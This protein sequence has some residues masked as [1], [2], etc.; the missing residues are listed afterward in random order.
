MKKFL[1]LWSILALIGFTFASES[2]PAFPMTIYW[3]TNLAW[4][5]LK[6]YDWSNHEI[7]SYEIT[8]AG[9]YWSENA[10]VLPLS[11][12]SFEGG[13]SFKAIYN[14]QEY[15]LES[16]DDSNRWE[17]C[18][19]KN[20]IT[21][22][23]ENCRY[24]LVFTGQA[25]SS[26][27]G[28][29]ARLTKD[30]CPNWDYSDSYYDGTCEGKKSNTHNSSKNWNSKTTTSN[31]FSE[32]MNDAYEFAYENWITTKKN[33]NQANMNWS[34]TRIAMAK[35]LSQYAVN[36]LWMSPDPDNLR[37]CNFSDVTKNMDVAYDNWVTLACQLW[38]MWVWITNFRPN[39]TVTRAQFGTALSRMLYGL[40]DGK[41]HY[42]STHLAKLKKEWII[43]NDNPTLKEVR[44]YVMLMLMRSAE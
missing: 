43:S 37:N 35:M 21:F 27:W 13:L 2:F 6:V 29:W 31:W 25:R 4:W 38:I 15:T 1:L 7:S 36:V 24:D 23:S 16:I 41:D 40:A 26:W 19:S 3:N 32:E 22:V 44:W 39:E 9:K 34:L 12:N 5:T 8:S 28:G 42:Y 11:L 33:I 10:F 14:W 17:W 20:S 18:P 30:N